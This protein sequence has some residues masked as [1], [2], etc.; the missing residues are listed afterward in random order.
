MLPG[1][2]PKK[3][4]FYRLFLK[5]PHEVG[6]TYREHLCFSFGL[7]SDFLKGGAQ[8]IVHGLVPA[9]SET[10]STDTARKVTQKMTHARDGRE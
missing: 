6:M 5:H 2:S 10:S 9:L 1:G 8:A 3:G 4:L 7:A